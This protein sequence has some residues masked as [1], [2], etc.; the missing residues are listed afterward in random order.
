MGATL[1]P[2]SQEPARLSS[3]IPAG[4]I[5]SGFSS[6]ATFAVGL[7]AAREFTA[8]E[9]GVYAL[10]TTAFLLAQRLPQQ[11]VFVPSEVYSLEYPENQR[12]RLFDTSLRTGAL[13]VLIS[14]I[15]NTLIDFSN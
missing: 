12:L 4:L 7:Y 1:P 5:D 8:A 6:A 10:L 11:L 15:K 13:P 2:G 3:K 9:L 14:A